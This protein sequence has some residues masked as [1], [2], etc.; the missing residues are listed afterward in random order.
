MSETPDA[1]LV[2]PYIR[3]QDHWIKLSD[4]TS[5]QI[6]FLRDSIVKTLPGDLDLNEAMRVLWEQAY[7]AGRDDAAIAAGRRPNPFGEPDE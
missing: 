5:E 7:Q 4:L 6:A 1:E 3:F 2:V